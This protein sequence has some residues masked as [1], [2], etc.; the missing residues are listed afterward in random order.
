MCPPGGCITVITPLVRDVDLRYD[1]SFLKSCVGL[2]EN[3]IVRVPEDGA[4]LLDFLLFVRAKFFFSDAEDGDTL[5]VALLLALLVMHIGLDIKF[6]EERSKGWR[7]EQRYS[8]C[9]VTR[10]SPTMYSW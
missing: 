2:R 10:M 8:V 1:R 9:G 3:D 5:A 4:T 7:D 6:L